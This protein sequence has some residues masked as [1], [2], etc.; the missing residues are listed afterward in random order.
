MRGRLRPAAPRELFMTDEII[1]E[2]AAEEPA[3]EFETAADTGPEEPTQASITIATLGLTRMSLQELKEKAPADLQAFAESLD[4]ENANAMRKQ[5]I[6][7]AVLK[8]LA[9]E[10]VEISGSGTMEVMPDGF[11]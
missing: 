8:T 9:D 10:G 7:F 1:T 5:D 4:I 6:M 3:A 2:P 11:G